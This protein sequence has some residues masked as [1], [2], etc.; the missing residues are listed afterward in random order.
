MHIEIRKEIESDFTAVHEVIAAAFGQQNEANLVHLLRLNDAFIPELSLVAIQHNKIVGHV[1]FTEIK[2]IDDKGA[3]FKSIALAPVS[4][5]PDWQK[6]GIGIRLIRAG[7]DIAKEMGYQSVIVLGHEHYYPKFG[8]VPAAKWQI[9][10]PFEVPVN[11]FM[12]LELRDFG[13]SGVSGIV[14][15][16]QEFE[17]V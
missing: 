6:Q 4:V 13:L 1:L 16:P 10:P 3:V 7:L 17:Q 11:V 2:I 14:Q 9:K 15:Y 8:F 12:A 5:A